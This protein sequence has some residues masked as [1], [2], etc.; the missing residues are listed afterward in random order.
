MRINNYEFFDIE[1][2]EKSKGGGE[3]KALYYGTP[4]DNILIWKKG[5]D[6]PKA[7]EKVESSIEFH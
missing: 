4:K 3:I 7:N 6:L 1:K 5:M 2:M